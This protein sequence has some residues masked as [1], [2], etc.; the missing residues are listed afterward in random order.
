MVFSAKAMLGDWQKWE[1]I[2]VRVQ[3]PCSEIQSLEPAPPSLRR[4]LRCTSCG[5]HVCNS[6]GAI[7]L[8]LVLREG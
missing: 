2:K 3:W 8:I 6:E 5:S 7:L 1:T 4:M